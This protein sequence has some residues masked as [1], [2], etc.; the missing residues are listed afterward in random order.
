MTIV[1]ACIKIKST[2]QNSKKIYGKGDVRCKVC[3]KGNTVELMDL[4]LKEAADKLARPNSVGWYGHA[5]RRPKEDVSIKVMVHKVDGKRKQG[6]P[7]I[8]WREQVERNVRRID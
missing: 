1:F 2:N 3:G 5:L 6:R 8:E 4:G 7:R